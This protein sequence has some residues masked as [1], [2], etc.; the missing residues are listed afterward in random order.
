MIDELINTYEQT[1][2]EIG[3]NLQLFDDCDTQYDKGQ[4]DMVVQILKDLKELKNA[5]D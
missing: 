2:K 4:Y 3:E 5:K 1:L